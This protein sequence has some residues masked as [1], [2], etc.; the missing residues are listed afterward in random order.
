[1][2]LFLILQAK[3]KHPAVKQE[4]KRTEKKLKLGVRH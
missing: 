1:M 4:A 2:A 3:Q